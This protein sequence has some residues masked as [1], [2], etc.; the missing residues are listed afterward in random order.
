MISPSMFGKYIKPVYDQLITPAR[1]KGCVIRMHSDGNIHSLAEELTAGGV[2]VINLQDLVN[3]IEWIKETLAGRVCID[4]DIDRQ[5]ITTE[6]TPEQIDA[7]L[8]G[9]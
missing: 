7:L 8:Q 5:H 9:G 6:G 2:E 1:K 3:G 4:L